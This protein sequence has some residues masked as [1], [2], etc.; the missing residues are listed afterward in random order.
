VLL[1]LAIQA[2][3]GFLV[4]RLSGLNVIRPFF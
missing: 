4:T 3:I 2:L 1:L